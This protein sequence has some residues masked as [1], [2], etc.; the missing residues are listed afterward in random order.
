MIIDSQHTRW[1]AFSVLILLVCLVFYIPYHRD[2]LGH[3]VGG[4]GHGIVF[5]ILGFVLMFIAGLLG[6]R[7]RVRVWRIGRAQEWMRAHIWLGL[8]SFPIILFH[9][10]LR[11]GGGHLT[12]MLM[13]LF[14]IVIISGIIGLIIQHILPRYMFTRIQRETIYEQIPHVIEQLRSE[15]DELIKRTCGDLDISGESESDGGRSTLRLTQSTV[16]TAAAVATEPSQGSLTL[17]QFYLQEVRPYLVHKLEDATLQNEAT[18][19]N[20]FS[21]IRLLLPGAL[22]EPLEDLQTLCSERRDLKRQEILHYWLHGWLLIH[23]P[24]AYGLLLLSVIHALFS[25]FF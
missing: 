1:I 10:G 15:A 22:H 9:S 13:Y 12:R 7:K 17:R 20:R 18:G 25:V 23:I 2:S 4:S 24:I 11:L 3:P 16:T 6:A 21:H 5:G 19:D 8:I 14:I